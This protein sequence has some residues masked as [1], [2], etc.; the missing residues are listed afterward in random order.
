MLP[1]LALIKTWLMPFVTMIPA[2]KLRKLYDT[3]RLHV[4]MGNDLDTPND[5]LKYWTCQDF[6]SC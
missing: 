2:E 5:K 3:L 6:V 1:T 4:V